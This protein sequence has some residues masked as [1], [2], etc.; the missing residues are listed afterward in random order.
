MNFSQ[1]SVSFGKGWYHLGI[2]FVVWKEGVISFSDIKY[3]NVRRHFPLTGKHV[4][5]HLSG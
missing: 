5:A 1:N 3:A 4:T 2:I